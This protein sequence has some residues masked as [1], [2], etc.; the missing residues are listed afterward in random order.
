MSL[1][2]VLSTDLDSTR[3][4]VQKM[5]VGNRGEAMET[6]H[7]LP[8]FY[9]PLVEFVRQSTADSVF[10]LWLNYNLQ[11]ANTPVLSTLDLSIHKADCSLIAPTFGAE[12]DEFLLPNLRTLSLR[13]VGGGE[14]AEVGLLQ[15]IQLRSR[16]SDVQRLQHLSV[17]VSFVQEFEVEGLRECVDQ[18]TLLAN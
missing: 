7:G 16:S 14:R 17:A 1:T 12:H 6:F 5:R 11:L 2:L 4:T 3:F 9:G 10:R 18:L 15:Q 13:D 8:H